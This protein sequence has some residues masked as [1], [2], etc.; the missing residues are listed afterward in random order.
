MAGGS[1]T[2]VDVVV[3]LLPGGEVV[4]EDCQ[5]VRDLLLCFCDDVL[6]LKMAILLAILSL[7][8]RLRRRLSAVH[9]FLNADVSFQ[10]KEEDDKK[11]REVVLK[12]L[13]LYLGGQA[14]KFNETPTPQ[15][16]H[17]SI[18]TRSNRGR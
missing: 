5:G 7:I 6:I 14:K 1:V 11:V 13:Y 17:Q 3:I 8:W 9:D 16:R 15:T 12:R 2:G 10:K 18:A 4:P